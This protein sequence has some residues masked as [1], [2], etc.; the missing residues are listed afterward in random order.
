MWIFPVLFLV[1][2]F[3][4]A[5]FG[6][7]RFVQPSH[8]RLKLKRMDNIALVQTL[9]RGWGVLTSSQRLERITD[10]LSARMRSARR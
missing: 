5:L 4:C 10:E 3:A 9:A 1:C 8:D 6:M 2:G 7:G